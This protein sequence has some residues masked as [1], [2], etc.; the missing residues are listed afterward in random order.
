MQLKEGG[1]TALPLLELLHNNPIALVL[2]LLQQDRSGV[3][4]NVDGYVL[5]RYGTLRYVTAVAHT[6]SD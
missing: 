1:L 2:W 6:D 3:S 4:P 5:L